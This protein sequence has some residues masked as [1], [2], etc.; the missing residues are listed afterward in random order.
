MKTINHRLLFGLLILALMLGCRKPY[1]PPVVA[2]TSNFLV[3]DGVINT[4]QDSTVI[5]LSRTVALTSTVG[6][7]PELNAVVQVESDGN[8]SYPLMEIGNGNYGAMGLNLSTANK[9]RLK[10]TT[11]D[12]KTYESDFV[13]VKNAPPIDSVYYKV[14]NN[15][16]QISADTHDPLNKTIYY[17]WDFNET[18]VIHSLYDS[19]EIHVKQPNDTVLYRPLSKDIYSCWITSK[20]VNIVLGSTAKLSK[21]VSINNAINFLPS[22]NE[23]IASRY[24]IEVKQYALTPEAFNYWQQLAK[25]TQQLGSIFDAQP[26]ELP[27]NIH[28]ITNPKEPVLGYISAGS[29]SKSRI[30]IDNADL[31]AWQASK[32][33]YDGCFIQNFYYH[34]PE[35]AGT[36]TVLANIYNDW[37]VPVAEISVP[38]SATILGFTAA[39]PRCVDCTLRGTNIQP[40]FWINR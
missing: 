21:D 24:S 22:T 17:R 7:K 35:Q 14:Q 16:V 5:H 13:P 9:Y 32:P 1:L 10:I 33:Y 31:P 37:N 28:C 4:G 39:A 12:N 30:F 20:S 34:D 23:K 8:T 6:T 11:S 26:S 29:Y 19:H 27:G 2:T 3:V 38:G 15:G 25:N 18:Y 36:N 40:D